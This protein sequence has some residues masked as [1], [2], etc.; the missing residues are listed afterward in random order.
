MIAG[1]RASLL[2]HLKEYRISDPRTYISIKKTHSVLMRCQSKHKYS[3][4]RNSYF[5]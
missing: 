3:R 1:S 2:Q 5:S 4:T